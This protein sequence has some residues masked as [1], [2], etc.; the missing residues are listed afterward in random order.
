MNEQDFLFVVRE[1]RNNSDYVEF[2]IDGIAKM[3]FTQ[4]EVDTITL[5]GT[6]HAERVNGW[7][8]YFHNSPVALAAGRKVAKQLKNAGHFSDN[9]AVLERQVKML[10]RA[11]RTVMRYGY[12]N[13]K[14]NGHVKRSIAKV[15]VE[16]EGANQGWAFRLNGVHDYFVP[17]VQAEYKRLVGK[18]VRA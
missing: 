3:V 14:I 13:V 15:V 7:S 8:G 6:Q 16:D 1:D 9:E 18:A 17:A 5:T 4:A 12:S 2:E 11:T 10:S